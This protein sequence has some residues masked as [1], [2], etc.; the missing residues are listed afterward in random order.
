MLICPNCQLDNEEGATTCYSCGQRL[1]NHR[2]EVDTNSGW[3]P[4]LLASPEEEESWEEEIASYDE[5]ISVD[6]EDANLY[7]NRGVAY[8]NLGQHAEAIRDYDKAISLGPEYVDAFLHRGLAYADLE[9]YQ[10]A[11]QDYGECIRLDAQDSEA[12]LNRGVAY[13]SLGEY[14]AALDDYFQAL[15][16]EPEDAE[17][18]GLAA[19]AATLLGS[20]DEAA[21]L[22]DDAVELGVSPT[23]LQVVI[24]E[25]KKRR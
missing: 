16:L 2:D 21:G 10:Q 24:D 15:S 19:L 1:E 7:F 5:A 3:S 8:D 9:Q 25:L 4:S 17:I 23:L 20:D 12:Y 11:I 18:Y 22:Q 13:F 14:Q 6:P